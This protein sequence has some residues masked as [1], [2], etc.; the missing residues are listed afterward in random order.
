MSNEQNLHDETEEIR[1]ETADGAPELQEHDRFAELEKA[2]EEAN[3]KA[4]YAAAETQNV[5]RGLE[6]VLLDASAY[7]TTGFGRVMLA[8]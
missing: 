1:K 4:L 5:R 6:A 3:N 2:L 8:I 7:A